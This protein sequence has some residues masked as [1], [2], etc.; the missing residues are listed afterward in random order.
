MGSDIARVSFDPTRQYRSVVLQQGRVTLEADGNEARRIASEA[1]RLETIDLVGPAGTPDDGYKVGLDA[2][3]NAA[4]LPGTMYLGG[5]RLV[6]DEPVE[7]DNQPDWLDMPKQSFGGPTL[8]ALLATEQSVC[9]IEDQPLRE[10]ALG[11]PDSAART[12]LMQPFLRLPLDGRTCEIAAKQVDALLA[13]DGVTLDPKTFQLLSSA[14]LQVGFVPPAGPPDPCD[15]PA[16]GGYLGAD[17]QMIRVTVVSF[18]PQNRTGMLLWGWNNASFLYRGA[19]SGP[20]ALALTPIPVDAE[21]SPQQNQAIEVL[22]TQADL[23]DGNDIAALSGQVAVLTQA[24]DPDTDLMTLPTGFTLPNT[25]RPLFVRL[26]QAMVPFTSGM[27]VALDAVS[28]LS[29]TITMTRMPTHIAARPFWHFAVRP[30]TPT[31][32]YPQRYQEAPQPPDGPRQWLCDLAVIDIGDRFQVLDDCRRH[33]GPGQTACCGVTMGPAEVMAAGGL[34]A[35]LDRLASTGTPGTLSLRPGVYVLASPLTLTQKHEWLTLEGCGDGVILRTDPEQV[36]TFRGGAIIIKQA[37]GI[38]LNGLVIELPVVPVTIGGVQVAVMN[39]LNATASRRLTIEG[40]TFAF[41]PG[42]RTL[43]AGG[44]VAATPDCTDLTVR[45]NTFVCGGNIAETRFTFGVLISAG[46]N[47]PPLDDCEISDNLFTGL[48]L[49]VG[50]QS[51]IGLVRCCDNRVRQ[52][53]GGFY[54]LSMTNTLAERFAERAATLAERERAVEQATGLP[55][56]PAMLASVAENVRKAIAEAGALTSSA[57]GELNTGPAAEMAPTAAAESGESI[58]S[59]LDALDQEVESA[60]LGGA[61]ARPALHLRNNDVELSAAARPSGNLSFVGLNIAMVGER[62]SCAALIHGNRIETP[63]TDAAAATISLYRAQAVVTANLFTQ[64]P[65]QTPHAVPCLTS[66][67][68]LGGF[69][70]M[71]NV[72]SPQATIAPTRSPPPTNDWPFLNTIG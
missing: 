5:W 2:S 70:V 33:F 17:N 54:L 67:I 12:R 71:G 43:I 50:L 7:L 14:R 8:V 72:I 1:L 51:A 36:Q 15:P 57:G 60:G 61:V 63:A 52:C 56:S 53:A 18:N 47:A 23:G 25:N 41:K 4:V 38:G 20:Q 59:I 30:A 22:L 64:L 55:T 13:E 49:P 10:V 37:T 21:H 42:D 66:A 39:G 3:G 26:W 44:A 35:A 58:D 32:V 31:L 62:R 24:Y 29:V 28:G 65:G 27:P 6:L 11:G 34:Q 46:G 69:E 68:F 40:C 48:G 45:G 16:Q 19:P 9:A